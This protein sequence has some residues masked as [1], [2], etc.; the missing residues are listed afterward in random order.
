MDE[1][2][3]PDYWTKLFSIIYFEQLLFDRGFPYDLESIQLLCCINNKAVVMLHGRHGEFKQYALEQGTRFK[4]LKFRGHKSV[5]EAITYTPSLISLKEIMRTGSF[6]VLNINSRYAFCFCMLYFSLN[7]A[8]VTCFIF[9]FYFFISDSLASSQN[10]DQLIFCSLILDDHFESNS[11]QPLQPYFPNFALSTPILCCACMSV[12]FQIQWI[13]KFVIF[14]YK[15]CHV[16]VIEL[17]I[18]HYEISYTCF[19]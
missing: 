13:H 11:L 4:Q 3:N 6:E 16:K 9:Y 12:S 15:I 10:L 19:Y 2:G 1:N 5:F 17:F 14:T 7:F 18:R 8:N